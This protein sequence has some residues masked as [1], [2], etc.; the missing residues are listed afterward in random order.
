MTKHG[1]LTRCV[2]GSP[3]TNFLVK[4]QKSVL[5]SKVVKQVYH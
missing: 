2:I 1:I 3:E 4:A 5:L